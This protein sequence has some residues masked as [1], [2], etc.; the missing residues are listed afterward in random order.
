MGQIRKSHASFSLS[1]LSACHRSY[2]RNFHLMK[3]YTEVRTDDVTWPQ[4]LRSC[5]PISLR[6]IISKTVRDIRFKLTT[7]GKPHILRVRCSLHVN[8]DVTWPRGSTSWPQSLWRTISWH[9]CKVDG[10]FRVT[11]SR[12]TSLQVQWYR[13][14]WRHVTPKGPG[15]DPNISTNVRHRWLV[16]T[17]QTRSSAIA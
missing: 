6:L 10:W 3:F 16:Q 15:R 7:N 5:P 4:K 14:R 1:C 9:P 11:S 2:G 12:K 17:D 13:H 8:D